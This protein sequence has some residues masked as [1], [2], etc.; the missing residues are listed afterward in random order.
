MTW[1]QL[2]EFIENMKATRPECLEENVM[3]EAIG[4]DVLKPVSVGL[5]N[6]EPPFASGLRRGA[7]FLSQI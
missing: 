4:A 2:A 7:P 3:F 1:L 5:Y 6:N